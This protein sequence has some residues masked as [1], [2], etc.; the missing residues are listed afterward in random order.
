MP[1]FSSFLLAAAVAAAQ[2]PAEHR[3]WPTQ[4]PPRGVVIVEPAA[5]AVA[6]SAVVATAKGKHPPGRKHTTGDLGPEQML[7]QSLAGLAA[8]A[9]N[10]GRFDEMVWVSPGKG[11]DSVAWYQGLVHR[12]Q[13]QER[14]TLNPWDLLDR[15]VSKDI[16]KGYVLYQYDHSAGRVMSVRPGSDPSA[17]VATTLAGLLGGVLISEELEGAAKAH[18]LR[19]LA[20]A[21]GK[22]VAWCFA[23]YRDRLNRNFV[24][25]QDPQAPYARDLAIAQ[26]MLVLY[27]REE[28]TPSVLAWLNPLSSVIGWGADDEGKTVA[29]I[30]RFGHILLPANW[31][32]NL[33]L[34]SAGSESATIGKLP[35][36]DPHTIAWPDKSPAVAFVMSDGDNVSWLL[37][38]F[39]HNASYWASPDHGKF[40]L[41]WGVPC[42]CLAQVCPEA[43]QYLLATQ[44]KNTTIIPAN[45]GY[46][47]AD[48]FGADR[49]DVP[50]AE[51]LAR[52]AQRINHYQQRLGARTLLVVCMDIDSEE[53]R[54]AYAIYAREIEGLVGLFA[55]EYSPY[56]AGNGRVFWVKN[57]AGAEIPVATC[58]FCIWANLKS[59]RSGTPTK[60]ASLVNHVAGET[61]DAHD[62]LL[63]W[64]MTNAWSG[65]RKASSRGLP[66]EDAPPQTADMQHGV[67]PTYWC[68][69]KLNQNIRVVS[70]E[71]LLWRIRLQHEGRTA[72]AGP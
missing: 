7:V 27:G 52:H 4:A 16:V 71:E 37:G 17:N 64:T 67:T 13:L 65:F 5:P 29:Q 48:L 55:L 12:L 49:S 32:L 10:Q 28:P 1:L 72:P 34:L 53:A 20:D 38:S 68:V 15:Y 41:G 6:A 69:Q 26:R 66:A 50:R 30:S 23:Q 40:P 35:E 39:F 61:H 46:Y 42:G 25:S 8:Q 2:S 45:G 24:L 9:V 22:S 47:Y 33:T 70:P 36:F 51:L 43:L 63:C 57:R 44:R 19:L 54:Q 14:G 62:P 31:T 60:I 18:G 58:K 59:S 56:E 21:R 3:W 11:D